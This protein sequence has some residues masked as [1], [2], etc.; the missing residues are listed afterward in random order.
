M[1][2]A[3]VMA[4][5]VMAATVVAATGGGGGRLAGAGRVVVGCWWG[6]GRRLHPGALQHLQLKAFLAASAP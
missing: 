3:V 6:L 5:A 4:A 2:V 1:V